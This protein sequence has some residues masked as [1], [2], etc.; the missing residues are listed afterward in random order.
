MHQQLCTPLTQHLPLFYE[1]AAT[2][3]MIEH[4]INVL[5]RAIEFL[6]PGQI[7]VIALDAPLYALAKI[8]QW[9]WPD[10]HVEKKF[11]AIFGGLYIKMAMWTTW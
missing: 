4:G 7:P 6:N 10:T 5:H 3:A 8:T 1:K 11:V 9:N 2:A